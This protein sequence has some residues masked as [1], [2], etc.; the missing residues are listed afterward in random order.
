MILEIHIIPI[1]RQL[2]IQEHCRKYVLLLFHTF[3]DL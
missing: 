3:I 2:N 1:L